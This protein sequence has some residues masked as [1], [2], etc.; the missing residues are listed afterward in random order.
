V[1]TKRRWVEE[2]PIATLIKN[3]DWLGKDRFDNGSA[4]G[5]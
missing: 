2:E 5:P 3:A 1:T 4:K